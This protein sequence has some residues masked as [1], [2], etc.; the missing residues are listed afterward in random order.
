M[1]G[2]HSETVDRIMEVTGLLRPESDWLLMR[3]EPATAGP[4][5]EE[6]FR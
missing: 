1:I 6:A 3:D 2:T 5:P 4:L